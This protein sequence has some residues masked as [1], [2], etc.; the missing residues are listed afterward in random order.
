MNIEQIKF[1]ERRWHQK[2][3][4]V[5]NSNHSRDLLLHYV[6]FSQKNLSEVKNL[7]DSPYPGS[8]PFLTR[9]IEEAQDRLTQSLDNLTASL[10]RLLDL[11]EGEDA[12][13]AWDHKLKGCSA[14]YNGVTQQVVEALSAI[15]S[16]VQNPPTPQNIQN[17]TSHYIEDTLKPST[18]RLDMTPPELRHVTTSMV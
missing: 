9:P 15:H 14:E 11:G 3:S 8:P 5:K 12:T 13:S 7:A 6:V 2:K 1:S 17:P 4:R 16:P 18:L 10:A